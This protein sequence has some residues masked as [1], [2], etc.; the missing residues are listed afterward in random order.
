LSALLSSAPAPSAPAPRGFL[1]VPIDQVLPERDQPRR[2][3]D[4]GRLEELAASIKSRGV[5]QPILVRR[6]P[7][8]SYRIVAGE[9]RWRAA[10]LAGLPELPVIVKEVSEAE[11]FELALIENIQRMDLNPIE[12]AEAYQRLLT[13]HGL[14]QDDVATRVGK[15]RS[16][17]ANAL[18]LL[19][20]PAVVR[21]QVASGS[22]SVG[23]AK[24]LLGVD[25]TK[26]MSAL[27]HQITER[28]LSVRDTERLVQRL[29]S[30]RVATP[31]EPIPAD[32]RS[33]TR[34]LEKALDLPCSIEMK[35]AA[36][37]QLT[38]RFPTVAKAHEQL[39][40]FLTEATQ[41][42]RSQRKE[43]S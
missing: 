37:S 20:L 5:I 26:D 34:K 19:K 3:W 2:F 42:A 9:R 22:L 43:E 25:D 33:L 10:Q 32:L 7:E 28:G 36:V 6:L 31:R 24:V 39:H 4:A 18:R 41:E 40:R 17:V 27:A 14:K 35:S 30:P 23:H 21:E 38:I 11:A 13:D 12:E 1:T 8:G 16:S 15:E 29:K